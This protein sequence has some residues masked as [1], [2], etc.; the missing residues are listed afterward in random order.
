MAAVFLFLNQLMR[1]FLATEKYSR[2]VVV[3]NAKWQVIQYYGRA[4]PLAEK[5]NL[6]FIQRMDGGKMRVSTTIDFSNSSLFC[7]F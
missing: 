1:K 6:I 5:R 4:L 2:S 7:F 3:L